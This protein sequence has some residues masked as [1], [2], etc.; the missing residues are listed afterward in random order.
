MPP[1]KPLTRKL[2]TPMPLYS[3]IAANLLDQI[4]AGELAPGNRLPPERELSKLLGV[5]RVTVRRALRFLESQ[6]LLSRRQGAGTFITEPKIERRADKLVPFTHG[7][8][9][10]GFKPGA[11]VIVFE[12]RPADAHLAQELQLAVAAPIYHIERLR[13]LNEE[14]AML[15]C[16][17][18]P[19]QR[20]P[21]LEQFDL[22]AR[23]LYEILKTEYGVAVAQARQSLE[24]ISASEYEA[25]WLQIEPRAPLMLE[26]RLAFDPAGGP[27]EHGRDV[28][29]GD[30]FRFVTEMAP[31][32]S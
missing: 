4:E 22:G 12:T 18:V 20:F 11:R 7:M 15:E 32:E 16:L 29:R 31:L 17:T 9:R 5:N 27:V 30:R 6:G 8:Q 14:P 3:Q 10:R 23:S 1:V 24:A 28:Y 26:R 13:F 25:A 21:A 2:T 19:A